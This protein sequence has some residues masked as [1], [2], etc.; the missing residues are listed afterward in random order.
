MRNGGGCGLVGDDSKATAVTQLSLE[1]QFLPSP[2]D[3]RDNH[4]DTPAK[5]AVIISGELSDI[6]PG[7]PPGHPC[8]P[9]TAVISASL[10]GRRLPVASSGSEIASGR[11]TWLCDNN[12]KRG[13]ASTEKKRS[14][15]NYTLTYSKSA[16]FSNDARE[17]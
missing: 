8:S 9:T 2:R 11:H 7:F 4:R 12:N 17:S 6:G 3:H 14:C 16:I 5:T 13:K 1:I 15:I 10:I